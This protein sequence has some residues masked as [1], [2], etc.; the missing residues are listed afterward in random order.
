M[1]VKSCSDIPKVGRG[2]INW[3]NVL[4]LILLAGLEYIKVV[5]HRGKMV[6]AVLIGETDLEV[7]LVALGRGQAGKLST[8]RGL[9]SL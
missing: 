9:L 1:T 4:N 6:G 2:G 8:R 5:V 7:M 3:E